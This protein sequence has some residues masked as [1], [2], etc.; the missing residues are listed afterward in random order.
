M[1]KPMMFYQGFGGGGGGMGGAGMYTQILGGLIETLA[2]LA[3][4]FG[5]K[6][7][8]APFH[9]QL[10]PRAQG[11]A[12]GAN[13]NAFPQLTQ[14]GNLY[15][16]SLLDSLN[17]QDPF[18]SRNLAAGG[19]ATNQLLNVAR[20]ELGGDLPPDVINQIQRSD[21]YQSLRGGYAGSGMSHAL[22][23]RD[24]G[25]TSLDLMRQGASMLGQG[26]NSA[27]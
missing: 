22:T 24:L 4:G 2:G 1:K 20:S 6:P 21:A 5:S 12:I 25:L 14:L 16:S 9:R 27:Q 11:Q 8:V 19:A 13:I 26:G 15:T 7:Q 18:Y 10:L 23:A 3:G 17:R